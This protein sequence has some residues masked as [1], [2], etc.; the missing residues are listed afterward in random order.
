MLAGTDVGALAFW[1]GLRVVN[2]DGVI[3]DFRYQAYLRD[4]RLRAYLREQ[5]VT[6]V[7]SGLWDRAQT[8]TGRP[9][10]PMYRSRVD[11]RAERGEAYGVHRYYVYSYLYG[12]YSDVV[13]LRESDEVFRRALGEDG[14]AQVSYVV[15]RLR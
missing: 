7:A 9:V 5:G 14:V 1:T 4:G 6:H 11:P 10:E 3:S 12:V 2:L 13:P 15:W 8:Y